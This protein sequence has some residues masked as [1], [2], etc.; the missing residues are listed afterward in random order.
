V[1]PNAGLAIPIL[2]LIP[3]MRIIFTLIFPVIRSAFA[4]KQVDDNNRKCK[5]TQLTSLSGSISFAL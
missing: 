3:L 4:S 5:R 1:E 2:A